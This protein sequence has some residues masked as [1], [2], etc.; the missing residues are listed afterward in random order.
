MYS[1]FIVAWSFEK[2]NFSLTISWAFSNNSYSHKMFLIDKQFPDPNTPWW[3]T[4]MADIIEK[5]VSRQGNSLIVMCFFL[6]WSICRFMNYTSFNFFKKYVR[7]MDEYANFSNFFLYIDLFHL[8]NFCQ[9]CMC[10]ISLWWCFWFRIKCV[11][12]SKNL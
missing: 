9:Y 1:I 5:N 6:I 8:C 11:Q 2:D 7:I 12:L 3:Y 10:L 4:N